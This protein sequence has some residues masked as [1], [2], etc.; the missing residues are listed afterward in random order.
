MSFKK[1]KASYILSFFILSF[2]FAT[3]IFVVTKT[4]F[5]HER[6]FASIDTRDLSLRMQNDE[7]YGKIKP[8]LDNRCVTCHSCFNSPCQLNLSS[9]EGVE[10]GANKDNIYNFGIVKE[11]SPTRLSIDAPTK[12]IWQSQYFNFYPV[13]NSKKEKSILFHVLENKKAPIPGFEYRA[14]SSRMCSRYSNADQFLSLVRSGAEPNINSFMLDFQ[15]SASDHN[16]IPQWAQM[17]Y[18]FPPISNNEN[19][20]MINWIARGAPGPD[21]NLEATLNQPL[22]QSSRIAIAK[23]ENF[24]N[25]EKFRSAY[26]ENYPDFKTALSA[27][28]IYEHIFLGHIYFDDKNPQEFFRLVRAE[29]AIGDPIEISTRRPNDDPN[30][31]DVFPWRK[32]EERRKPGQPFYYR[33]KKVSQTLTHKS[34]LPFYLSDQRLA[35]WTSMFHQSDWH[36]QGNPALPD[37]SVQ[38]AANAFVLYRAIPEKVRYQFLLDDSYFFVMSF[39]K[40]PVCRGQTALDVIDDNF[41]VYFM[42]PDSDVVVR[43]P[44]FVDD[45]RDELNLPIDKQNPIEVFDLWEGSLDRLRI[46]KQALLD[47][48]FKD[49]GLSNADIWNGSN[50]FG[51][52]T[53]PNSTLTVYRHFDSASVSRGAL[54]QQPKTYWVMDYLIFED[55]YYNLVANYDVFGN[56]IHQVFTRHHMATSR[57]NSQD[58]FI[59]LMPKDQR[60]VVRAQWNR[61]GKNAKKSDDGDRPAPD[62]C[63]KNSFLLWGCEMQQN[64][65]TKSASR[66]MNLKYLYGGFTG[67]NKNSLGVSPQ[68]FV[69]SLQRQPWAIAQSQQS[70]MNLTSNTDR[71]MSKLMTSKGRFANQ[72]PELSYIRVVDSAS[73]QHK[74]YTMVH[75]R[76]HFN[77]AFFFESPDQLDVENDSVDILPTFVGSYVNAIFDVKSEELSDFVSRILSLKEDLDLKALNEKYLVSRYEN[78]NGPSRFWAIFDEL[79]AE[80]KRQDPIE[81]AIID[82]NR[83]VNK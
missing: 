53:N 67:E 1:N 71:V 42:K 77:V 63:R 15:T 59:S 73:G 34:H 56:V 18:G 4:H 9:Y 81:G 27:R 44:S 37:Y 29:N 75:N 70:I 24:F 64:L 48:T 10:R 61:D 40:G 57:I 17:P 6:I 26:V 21:S 30:G 7:F 19:Q 74:W 58:L 36:V 80:V 13:L 43:N 5:T 68:T 83:Y 54:G 51:Q 39:I 50:Y 33:F 46:K 3:G 76:E 25:G 22:A 41:W 52:G 31:A 2:F 60:A 32:E 14:E 35:L 11:K 72:L 65:F 8:V 55:I 23:W 66:K 28:Y 62:W 45:V 47:S 16:M 78:T 20:T 12:E 79:N 69:S 38:N 49:T 82:L